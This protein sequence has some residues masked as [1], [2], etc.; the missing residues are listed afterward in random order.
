M[1][2]STFNVVFRGGFLL[3]AAGLLMVSSC[4]KEDDDDNNNNQNPPTND[5][6]PDNPPPTGDS[7]VTSWS[8]AMPYPDD[9]ITFYGGPFAT[10][11]GATTVNCLNREFEILS[12]TATQLKVRPP[13]DFADDIPVASAGNFHIQ[14]GNN[15]DTLAWFRFKRPLE[16]R[17]FVDNV[18]QP[19]SAAPARVADSVVY[20]GSG[21]TLTGMT[22]KLNG[23]NCGPV[24]VDSAYYGLIGFRIPLSMA[25]GSNETDLTDGTLTVTNG[26]GKSYSTTISYAPTPDMQIN[27]FELAG[28]SGGTLSIS[29]MMSNGLVLNFRIH[30]RYLNSSAQWTLNGPSPA[31]GNLSNSYNAEQYV[32]MSP[33]S[34]QTGFYTFNV[35]QGFGS[36]SFTL[37]D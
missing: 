22:V 25:F 21:F 6:I 20:E 26:D 34:M 14:S 3:L 23:I 32:V 35:S 13:A 37:I 28:L 2:N 7:L 12:V 36:L 30:G 29:E 19:F 33:G 31:T 5:T 1:T 8:P 11:A 9:D 15:A 4:K 16:I 24:T 17:S 10:A 27:G 18:D